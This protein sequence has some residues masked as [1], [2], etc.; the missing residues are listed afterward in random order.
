[1]RQFQQL[2]TT[3][4]KEM[5]YPSA[6]WDETSCNTVITVTL[7]HVLKELLPSATLE[8]CLFNLHLITAVPKRH[9]IDFKKTC[10]ILFRCLSFCPADSSC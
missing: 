4:Y 9:A 7:S 2:R 10:V 3:T 5:C 8:N 6:N 1:M